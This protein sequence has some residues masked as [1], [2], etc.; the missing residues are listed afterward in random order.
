MDLRTVAESADARD[1][2]PEMPVVISEQGVRFH[3]PDE[4]GLFSTNCKTAFGRSTDTI[5]LTAALRA[6][7]SP[8]R[9]PHCFG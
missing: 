5:A 3:R 4:S 1:L 2:D 8:C 6:G 9:K 7:Y